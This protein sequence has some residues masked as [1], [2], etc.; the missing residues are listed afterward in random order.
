MEKVAKITKIFFLL[1]FGLASILVFKNISGFDVESITQR[2]ICP[3]FFII[4]LL[5]LFQRAF[6]IAFVIGI[7]YMMIWAPASFDDGMPVSMVVIP[8]I[9]FAIMGLPLF[10]KK[11]NVMP[12][13]MLG[14]SMASLSMVVGSIF[15]GKISF[16]IKFPTSIKTVDVNNDPETFWVAFSVYFIFGIVFLFQTYKNFKNK[17]FIKTGDSDD[18]KSLA[19]IWN[20]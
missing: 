8:M 10:F 15:T 14:L 2:L 6:I 7:A 19:Q 5:G 4:I 18:G 9:L 11:L 3:L 16:R 13:E 20:A 1:V 17:K 12:F